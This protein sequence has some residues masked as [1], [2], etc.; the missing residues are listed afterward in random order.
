MMRKPALVLLA[1]LAAACDSLLGIPS[2]ET[3]STSGPAPDASDDTTGDDAGG[4]AQCNPDA[5]TDKC[6]QCTDT[7]C[8]AEY[9]TC[10]ADPRC[11]DYYKSC[12]P[13]CK[14]DG[15][16]YAECVVSCDKIYGA[17]HALFAPYF[18]CT[19]LHCLAPCSNGPPDGCTTCLYASCSDQA[20]ACTADRE[21]DT[22]FNCIT[23]CNGTLDADSCSATC[24]QGVGQ[25]AQDELN[26]EL[27]CA[28]TYCQNACSGSL[29]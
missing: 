6:F 28:V 20:H 21:C 16:A 8:C 14:A 27:T 24:K 22:L 18:A 13:G 11:G 29:P 19:E 10:A 23:S 25:T 9:S 1:A 15:G 2:Q 12:L 26:A 7:Y 4:G 17:G 5:D 3:L